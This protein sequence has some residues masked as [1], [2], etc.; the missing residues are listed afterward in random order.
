MKIDLNRLER[1][2]E[3]LSKWKHSNYKG[4]LR[5]STGVGKTFGAML[6]IKH[7]RQFVKQDAFVIVCVPTDNL[8]TQWK[9]KLREQGLTS[10]YVDTIHTLV[11][12]NHECDFFILDEIHSYTGGEVFNTIFDCVKRKYTLGLTAK[13]RDKPEDNEILNNNAPIVDTIDLKEA[14]EKGFVS[15]F[16]VYNLGLNFNNKDKA[17][18]DHLNRQFYKYFSTFGFDFDIAMRA[19]KDSAL[20]RQVSRDIH[21]EEKVVKLHSFHFN[22]AMQARKKYLYQADALIETTKKIVEHFPN[23]KIITFSEDTSV[24]D[25]LTEVL[26]NSIA[27]HSNLKTILIDGKKYGAKRLKDRA[28]AGF[29]DNTYQILNTARALNMGQDVPDIDMS[30]KTSFNSTVIDSIQRLGRTLRKNGDKQA[31]EVNLYLSGTQSERWL[32]KS[33]TETPNVYWISDI[34][35]IV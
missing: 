33:Q 3:G 34:S 17:K 16:K 11:K 21:L 4:I 8:R 35:E 7:I 26:P 14:L 23:K 12:K 19:G 24:A 22:R 32:R 1:Q 15:E 13:E 2:K 30:I 20:A 10:V 6:A 9:E 29:K 18:Y 5:W 25:K 27:Y 31:I 28:L